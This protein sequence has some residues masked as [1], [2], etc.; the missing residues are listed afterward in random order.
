MD[1]DAVDT[2][3]EAVMQARVVPGLTLT[4]QIR[5]P[6]IGPVSSPTALYVALIPH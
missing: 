3:F 5:G 4:A 2:F 6:I 1:D